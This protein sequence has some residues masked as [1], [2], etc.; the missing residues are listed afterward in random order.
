MMNGQYTTEAD[1]MY[2]REIGDI[3]DQ[4]VREYLQDMCGCP[5]NVVEVL[6]T[7]YHTDKHGRTSDVRKIHAK[8][9][10]NLY[11]HY[12]RMFPQYDISQTTIMRA[13]RK[14]IESASGR[15]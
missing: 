15:K 11:N 13:L 4:H 3:A 10:K 9:A 2:E 12:T 1:Y 7:Y 8:Y 6:D 14:N 5:E